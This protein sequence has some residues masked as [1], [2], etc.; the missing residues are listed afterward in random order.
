MACV[1]HVLHLVTFT[2][3][4][5]IKSIFDM[6]CESIIPESFVSLDP[7]VCGVSQIAGAASFIEIKCQTAAIDCT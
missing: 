3:C 5:N 2:I 7:K 6:N 1:I 4:L